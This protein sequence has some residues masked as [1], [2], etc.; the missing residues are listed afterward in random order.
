MCTLSVTLTRT[1][2]GCASGLVLPEAVYQTNHRGAF[3]L[4][5]NAHPEYDLEIERL[6]KDDRLSKMRG[7]EHRWAVRTANQSRIRVVKVGARNLILANVELTWVQELSVP[8]MFYNSVLVRAILDH[9]DKDGSGLDR[10]AV[11]ELILGLHKLW[12]ANPCVAQF[13]IN[14][15]EAQ[16]NLVRAQL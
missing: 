2:A 10:P 11:V 7:M 14:M 5:L 13:I 4:M 15:K 6:S 3:N 12:E 9:L 16:N 1:T 8:E